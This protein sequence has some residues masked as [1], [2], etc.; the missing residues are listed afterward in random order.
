MFVFVCQCL[1]AIDDRPFWNA[2]RTEMV[3]V[4]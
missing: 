1:I 2:E 4:A 3:C